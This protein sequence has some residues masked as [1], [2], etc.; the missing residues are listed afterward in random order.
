VKCHPTEPYKH[1]I[2]KYITYH[3]QNIKNTRNVYSIDC[4]VEEAKGMF[5]LQRQTLEQHV[6]MTHDSHVM[7]VTTM[8]RLQVIDA[9]RIPHGYK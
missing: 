3:D 4:C 2:I 9:G 7:I 5:S 6:V 1:Q 8:Y